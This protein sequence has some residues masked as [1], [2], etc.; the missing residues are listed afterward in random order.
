MSS[1]IKKRKDKVNFLLLVLWINT[2]I[3]LSIVLFSGYHT[4]WGV[5]PALH[6]PLMSVTN[7]ISGITA[8]GGLLLMGGGYTP[9]NTI[10]TLSALAA[11][12]SSINIG[13]GFTV[14]QRMLDM[15]KRPS[16][17]NL[18]SFFQSNWTIFLCLIFFCPI[19][20]MQYCKRTY[21]CGNFFFCNSQVIKWLAATKSS[22][23]DFL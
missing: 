15:F 16:M 20:F 22:N 12:I 17:K 14:T 9:S 21:I 11:F 1:I 19:F 13:G 8:V 3:E 23:L 4:V 7:A 10:E 6:S 5:T 2:S 18:I